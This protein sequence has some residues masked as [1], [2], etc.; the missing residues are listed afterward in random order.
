M[1]ANHGP[2]DQSE[3]TTAPDTPGHSVPDETGV[4]SF[5]FSSLNSQKQSVSTSPNSSPSIHPVTVKDDDQHPKQMASTDVKDH[6]EQDK[7]CSSPTW[8]KDATRKERRATKRLEAERKELEKRMVKL[9]ESQSRLDQGIYERQSRRLSK[10]QPLGSSP[11]SSSANTERPRSSSISAFFSRSRASSAHGSDRE[12]RRSGEDARLG[13]PNL[14]LILPENFGSAVSRELATRHGTGLSQMSQSQLYKAHSLH[15][16][17]KSDDLRESWKMAEAWQ[18]QHGMDSSGTAPNQIQM[19]T[20]TNRPAP[21]TYAYRRETYRP[22]PLIVTNPNADLDQEKFTAALRQ[23][24]RTSNPGS[25]SPAKVSSASPMLTPLKKEQPESWPRGLDGAAAAAAR[26]YPN[27]HINGP[28]I[29]EMSGGAGSYSRAY[30]SS[31]LAMNPNT[32]AAPDRNNENRAPQTPSRSQKDQVPIPKPL[33]IVHPQQYQYAEPRGRFRSPIPSYPPAANQVRQNNVYAPASDP[34]DVKQPN[35]SEARRSPRVIPPLKH[36]GRRSTS[37]DRTPKPTENE[38]SAFPS[39]HANSP[40]PMPSQ[41]SPGAA[42]AVVTS[43]A[44]HIR[45]TSNQSSRASSYNTADEEVLEVPADRKSRPPRQDTETTRPVSL[46][47]PD[48]TPSD[49]KPTETVNPIKLA[50]VPPLSPGGPLNL[51]RRK[52]MQQT[53]TPQK[54]E[55]ISKIFVICCKCKYWQDMPSEIYA[56]LAC[57]ERLPSESRLARTFSRKKPVRNAVSPTDSSNARRMSI[58]KRM[59]SSNE[60]RGG[61]NTSSAG[62]PPTATSQPM[63]LNRPQC[64]WCGHGMGKSC[65]QSWSTLVSMRERFH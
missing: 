37:V 7:I 29:A 4:S 1:P 31:P 43:R 21:E 39:T 44:G 32:S 17:L 35:P 6:A 23:S 58:S 62:A 45:S 55:L 10:K 63:R 2:Q 20:V 53:R 28:P 15:S 27:P 56:R 3:A 50:N 9:E 30:K 59:Q 24:R 16:S 13:P 12:S 22:I 51:L 42:P 8:Q 19:T 18:K 14:P 61:Q 54:D 64:C 49:T 40:S 25:N 48:I 36:P 47:A 38:G 52:P 60:S 5:T 41:L 26:G 46:P 33:R 34:L 11:R 65:C 57:P